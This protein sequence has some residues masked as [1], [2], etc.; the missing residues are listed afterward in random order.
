MRISCEVQLRRI[1][2]L[3]QHEAVGRCRW[4][5]LIIGLGDEEF[6]HGCGRALAARLFEHGANQKP[7]HV[8]EES[9][10]LDD[11]GETARA[12]DPARVGDGAPVR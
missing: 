11:E 8:M 7:D 1:L 9:I 10:C 3:F 12:I 4:R 2:D 6:A 5:H